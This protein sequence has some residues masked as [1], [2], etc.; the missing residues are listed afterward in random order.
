[1]Y[2]CQICAK[3]SKPHQ[4]SFRLP[5]ELR[6]KKYPFRKEAKFVRKIDKKKRRKKEKIP[7]PGGC[8]MEIA[9]ELTV[10]QWCRDRALRGQALRCRTAG[11]EAL[12][13][14]SLKE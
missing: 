14:E 9:R 8:G 5:V 3:T 11:G 1:M 13:S 4:P 6:K 12:G 2:I 10:C 7:D